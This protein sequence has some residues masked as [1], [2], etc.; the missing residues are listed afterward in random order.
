MRRSFNQLDNVCASSDGGP[1]LYRGEQSAGRSML[2]TA[3]CRLYKLLVAFEV[4]VRIY[5]DTGQSRRANR[6][7]KPSLGLDISGSA[8]S[9]FIP[10]TIVVSPI[11]T[12]AEPSAVLIEP[13]LLVSMIHSSSIQEGQ[14]HNRPSTQPTDI[15]IE[16]SP[17]PSLSTVWSISLGEET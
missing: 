1:G 10:Q 6:P 4:V 15:D 16:V 13:V 14:E 3:N 11:L 7:M 12:S 8:T 17:R 2:G 9:A 5:D